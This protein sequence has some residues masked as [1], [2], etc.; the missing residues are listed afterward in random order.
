MAW[1]YIVVFALAVVGGT[2]LAAAAG[3]P[4]ILA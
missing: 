3:E 2:V 1:L 4:G